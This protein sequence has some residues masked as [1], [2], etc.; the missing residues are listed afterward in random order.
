MIKFL[1]CLPA[2]TTCFFAVNKEDLHFAPK[3]DVVMVFGLEEP[4]VHQDEGEGVVKEIM[5]HLGVWLKHV[6]KIER[7][8]EHKEGQIIG[9][10]SMFV[11]KKNFDLNKNKKH[12]GKIAI[13]GI[14]KWIVSLYP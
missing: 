5:K 14:W 11:Q 13:S 8:G 12:E 3:L 4:D 9:A 6:V 10:E 2:P 1:A 7:V